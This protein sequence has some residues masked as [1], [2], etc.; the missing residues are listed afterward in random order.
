ML[1]EKGFQCICGKISTS[2]SR[3]QSDMKWSFSLPLYFLHVIGNST[4]QIS[5]LFD[6]MDFTNSK[7]DDVLLG[8]I[9]H[10]HVCITPLLP[11][12]KSSAG[13]LQGLESG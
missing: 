6:K 9:H 3:A 11:E 13:N 12:P 10:R 5:L 1:C 2:V 4:T 7:L 8:K